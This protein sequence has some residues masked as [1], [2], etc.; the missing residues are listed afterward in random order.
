MYELHKCHFEPSAKNPVLLPAA[1]NEILRLRLIYE[2]FVKMAVN[3]ESVL[4]QCY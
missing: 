3:F 2:S 1:M 4:G